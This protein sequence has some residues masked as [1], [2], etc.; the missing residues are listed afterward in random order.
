MKRMAF[1]GVL[2]TTLLLS[3]TSANA[4]VSCNSVKSS[5]LTIEK[6][7]LNEI[8]YFQSLPTDL[9]GNIIIELGSSDDARLK[10]FTKGTSLYGVWKL[11]TNNPKCFTNTQKIALKNPKF[12]VSESYLDW[13]FYPTL[14]EL[15]LIF[16]TKYQSVYKY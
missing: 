4:A 7:I 16:R 11:G 10:K 8:K 5:I 3:G 1:V 9:D 14:Y 13:T 12:K 6:K 15:K 2:V